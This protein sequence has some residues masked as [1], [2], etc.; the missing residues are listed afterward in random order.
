MHTVYKFR[1]Q[2]YVRFT[3]GIDLPFG[4][5]SIIYACA[6]GSYQGSLL[7]GEQRWSGSDLRGKARQWSGSYHRSRLSLLGKIRKALAPHDWLAG[8]ELV[9]GRTHLVLRPAGSSGLH[10]W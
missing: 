7:A 9:E 4:M 6:K 2:G 1:E 8:I 5:V 10:V 3:P